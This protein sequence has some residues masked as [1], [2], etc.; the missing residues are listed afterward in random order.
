M[1]N[2]ELRL[3]TRDVPFDVDVPNGLN[4]P[5]IFPASADSDATE[6]RSEHPALTMATVRFDRGLVDHAP[7][8]AFLLQR[9]AQAAHFLALVTAQ[10]G[11]ALRH[12]FGR[13]DSVLRAMLPKGRFRR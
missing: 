3:V 4:P 12:P 8:M 6:V 5:T 9:I 13:R 2:R 1:L 11:A 7:G 10:V